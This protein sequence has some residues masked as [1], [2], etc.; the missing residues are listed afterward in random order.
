MLLDLVEHWPVDLARSFLI[1]D[2]PTDIA[3]AQAAGVP[4]HLF[5]GG[6]LDGRGAGRGRARPSVSRA[7]ISTRSSPRS[8]PKA[9]APRAYCLIAR[10][11]W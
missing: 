4:G 8:F 11:T 9:E 7:A 10:A 3:A 6:D 5:A 2:Q 1:G